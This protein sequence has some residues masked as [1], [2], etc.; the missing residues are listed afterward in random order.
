VIGGHVCR[1]QVGHCEEDQVIGA[2]LGDGE[3]TFKGWVVVRII[4][5]PNVCQ[6]LQGLPW[7]LT[8]LSEKPEKEQVSLRVWEGG[9]SPGPDSF[10]VIWDETPVEKH[11]NK[12]KQPQVRTGH[13]Q[14]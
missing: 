12:V 10:K 6:P 11:K 13:F 14:P 7:G 9:T 1:V 5:P 2:V 3:L 4:I 8:D